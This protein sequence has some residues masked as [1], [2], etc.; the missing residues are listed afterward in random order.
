MYEFAPDTR[1]MLEAAGLPF[2]V[3]QI[4]AEGGY[5]VLLVS[6]GACELFGASRPQLVNYL[7]NKSYQRMHPDDAGKLMDASRALATQDSL[8]VVFRMKVGDAYRPLLYNANA[9]HAPDGTRLIQVTYLDMDSLSQVGE[10]WFAGY[11]NKQTE[12]FFRDEVTGLPNINH[13]NQF[14]EGTVK[15]FLDKGQKPLLVLLDIDGMHSYNERYGYAAGDALLKEAGRVIR[16]AF[17]DDLVVRHLEDHFI[18][19]TVV[20]DLQQ[21][22]NRVRRGVCDYA[23]GTT[24]DVKAGVYRYTDLGE[25]PASAVDKARR[26][27]DSIRNR[28]DDHLRWYGVEV[29]GSF[30]RRNYVLGHYRE[31]IQ[32][33]WIKV[34]YQP[35]VSTLSAQVCHCE[36]LARWIDPTYGMLSPADFVTVLEENHKVWELD[37]EVIRQVARDIH[38]TAGSDRQFPLFSVNVSRNDLVIPDFHERINQI[39]KDYGVSHDKIA[40]EI[41]ESALVDHEELIGKHIDQFHQ[42]G[43]EVWLDDFGSGY[44]SFIALQNFDFDLLKIDMQFLRHQNERTPEILAGIIGL[45]KRLGIRSVTEGVETRKQAIYLRQI[46]C[47]VLQGFY[48]SKPVAH[49]E[50]FRHMDELGLSIEAAENLPFCQTLLRT[51]V[52]NLDNPVPGVKSVL[53]EGTKSIS[54]LAE[55][56]GRLRTVYADDTVYAW[57]ERM[58]VSS[59]DEVNNS[60][61]DSDPM[62]Q[63]TLS[64]CA[65]LKEVGQV[66]T[67]EVCSGSF[68]GRMQMV[69]VADDGRRR[70]FV[71][72]CL[73]YDG[74][75]DV[76]L[77]ADMRPVGQSLALLQEAYVAKDREA[78]A[79]FNKYHELRDQIDIMRRNANLDP[80]TRLLNRAGIEERLSELK[81]SDGAVVIAAD[82]DNFKLFNDLYGHSVGDDLLK[83]L[84]EHL[85]R[86]VRDAGVVARVG[87]DEFQILLWHSNEL[88]LAEARSF[89]SRD[90]TFMSGGKE[91]TYQIS[92]GYAHYPRQADTY[93][94][95]CELADAALYHAK[96]SAV[97]H[98]CCYTDEM[99][100]DV[101]FRLGFNMNDLTWNAPNSLFIYEAHDDEKILYANLRC[102]QLFGC[103]DV[104]DFFE[105]VGES[106]RNMVHPDDLDRVE[107]EIA[108]QIADPAL[109]ALDHVAYRIV[110][111]DGTVKNVVDAGR[112][113]YHRVFGNI[114][115]V[116]L[117]DLD[118]YK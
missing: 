116:G 77:S 40:I 43:F 105:L 87:G 52:L 16:D 54:I 48:F 72:T 83:D 8:S 13:F 38:D 19:I 76:R 56:D 103:D 102:A 59:L 53:L 2:S 64:C 39:L 81:A 84:S 45:T 26:A 71:Q 98:F 91:Y 49:D 78:K 101:R 74:D 89:F 18:V 65:E 5:D 118:S 10:S 57:M 110:C 44:S 75:E 100:R 17:P 34:F 55:V 67:R 108:A 20:G 106:F 37:L 94:K 104:E 15:D 85:Q 22:F 47:G 97:E 60:I 86:G 113:V 30:R 42:D 1:S 107:H 115:Y 41:T 50:F 21:R 80:L 96:L 51:N 32:K 28:P 82:I 111:K 109:Q 99:K 58:G 33:G 6:D 90:H 35:L 46:G 66:T 36:A 3:L 25:E 95:L 7:N 4:R 31:A 79:Y 117:I 92:G 14:A 93:W 62:R 88:A 12:R 70:G 29:E 27:V 73:E 23:Q 24:L 68:I 9:F 69:L 114:F 112:L 61:D 63:A 11:L